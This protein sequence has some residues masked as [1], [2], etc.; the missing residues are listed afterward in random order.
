LH[1]LFYK[2]VENNVAGVVM[3]VPVQS[4]FTVYVPGTF[5]GVIRPPML[6]V[7]EAETFPFPSKVTRP[8]PAMGVKALIAAG[9]GPLVVNPLNVKA[10]V[11]LSVAALQT[12]WASS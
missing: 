4:E 8:P 9:T 2:V 3:K 7:S 1:L 12:S 10:Y 5:T 11:P 6:T